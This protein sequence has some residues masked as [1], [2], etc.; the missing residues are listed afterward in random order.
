MWARSSSLE[1]LQNFARGCK[2]PRMKQHSK[3]SQTGLYAGKDIRFGNTISFSNKKSRRTWKPNVQ[4]KRLWSETLEK[5]IRFHVTTHAL[6]C[7]ENAGGID[8]Y[9]LK[10][11]DRWLNSVEGTRAKREI[12]AAIA[13]GKPNPLARAMAIAQG[14]RL[15]GGEKLRDGVKEGGPAQG[16]EQPEQSPRQ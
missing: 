12:E 5:W 1:F 15:E 11:P 7:V 9:L 16:G 13:G 14:S 8:R 2:N 4:L 3:R 6:R 10:M